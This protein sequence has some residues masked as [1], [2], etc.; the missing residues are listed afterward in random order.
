MVWLEP[1][2][3]LKEFQ[4]DHKEAQVHHALMRHQD[5]SLY[6]RQ[7]NDSY[8]I[9]NYR[10]EPRILE[11]EQLK[12]PEEAEEM[13]SLVDFRQV[14]LKERIKSLIGFSQSLLKKR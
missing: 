3:E 1:F 4:A 7:W 6:F 9:G 5:Y 8:V 13:P 12:K 14:I 10:H 11:S 2:E